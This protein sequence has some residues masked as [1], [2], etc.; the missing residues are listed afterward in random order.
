MPKIKLTSNINLNQYQK[1]NPVYLWDTVTKGFGIK[2]NPSGSHKYVVMFRSLECKR[3]KMSQLGLV[4]NT[5]IKD[6][7]ITAKKIIAE[8]FVPKKK[9][10]I[11]VKTLLNEY[12]ERKELK[13]SSIYDMNSIINRFF[14]VDTEISSFTNESVEKWYLSSQNKNRQTTTDKAKRYM[15]TMFRYAIAKKWIETNPFSIIADLKIT[16]PKNHRTEYLNEK[17]VLNYLKAISKSNK[18]QAHLDMIKFYLLTGVRKGEI[19]KAKVRDNFIYIPD[20]KNGR[21]LLIPR[22]LLID[23]FLYLFKESL[24]VDIRKTLYSLS[25]EINKKP[26]ITIHS[27]RHTFISLAAF[28]E[29]EPAVIARCVNHSPKGITEAVYTHRRV[30]IQVDKAFQKVG[31]YLEGS[32]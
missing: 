2:L 12:T 27:L 8:R 21:D 20:T 30:D 23:K 25:K 26:A 29:I 6:A 10:K 1:S 17:E 7:R 22:N 9:E 18:P 19:Y 4:C 13:A 14:N 31:D 3:Q 15:H 28:L 24:T 16:Y 5:N 32:L 11:T